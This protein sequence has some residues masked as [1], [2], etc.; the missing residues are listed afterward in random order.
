MKSE[1]LFDPVPKPARPLIGKGL[2]LP[3]MLVL[4]LGIGLGLGLTLGYALGLHG[5]HESRQVTSTAPRSASAP[6]VPAQPDGAAAHAAATPKAR[7]PVAAPATAPDLAASDAPLDQARDE[8]QILEQKKQLLQAQ[9][10]GSNKIIDA[11][12]QQIAELERQ[13]AQPDAP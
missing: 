4:G 8:A 1:P 2:L 10:E 3:A 11:K 12:A 5:V 9:I 13:L 6:P 7:A